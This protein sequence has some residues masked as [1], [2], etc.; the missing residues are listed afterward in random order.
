MLVF[1]AGELS[2]VAAV[3]LKTPRNESELQPDYVKQIFHTGGA[4]RK[5]KNW[6]ND[7]HLPKTTSMFAFNS[8]KCLL[9]VSDEP[10]LFCK[11]TLF[12]TRQT[13]ICTLLHALGILN[14]RRRK[15]S[16]NQ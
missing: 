2:Y 5:K 8:A 9:E 15:H 7:P 6:R 11:I 13:T 1:I 10:K 16:W 12:T 3:E 4:E 14:V